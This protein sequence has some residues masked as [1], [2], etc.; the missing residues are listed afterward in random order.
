MEIQNSERRISE[1]SASGERQVWPDPVLTQSSGHFDE[2]KQI[3][4]LDGKGVRE[5]S[6]E[7]N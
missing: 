7:V 6:R 2:D 3:S 1:Y 4:A 5:M